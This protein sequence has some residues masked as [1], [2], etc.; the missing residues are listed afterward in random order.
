MSDPIGQQKEMATRM[1][2]V[3]LGMQVSGR[4]G[5]VMGMSSVY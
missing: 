5:G 2:V 4:M 1:V 3:G